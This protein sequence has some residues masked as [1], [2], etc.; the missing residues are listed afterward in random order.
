TG[1]RRGDVSRGGQLCVAGVRLRRLL[2]ASELLAR[3]RQQ[4]EPLAT[5]GRL[6]PLPTLQSLT[7]VVPPSLLR[8]GAGGEQNIARGD[9][10]LVQ[11]ATE[12]A[13]RGPGPASLQ[14]AA[15][16]KGHRGRLQVREN[17]DRL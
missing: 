4:V 3:P 6:Q 12:H 16:L 17:A 13:P 8:R 2:V 10:C 9:L 1:Q 11:E 7:D 14:H 15:G 5:L